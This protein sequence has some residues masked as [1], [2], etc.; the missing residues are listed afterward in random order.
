MSTDQ[1]LVSWIGSSQRTLLV[2]GVVAGIISLVG[3]FITPVVFFQA[4]LFAFIFWVCMSLGC[5]GVALLHQLAGGM[6]GAIIIRFLEAGM[7]TLPL[8]AV[9]FLPIIAGIYTLYPWSNAA[10]VAQDAI[11]QH[12]SGYLNAP[13]FIIRAVVYFV[14][15]ILLSRQI[16]SWS[17]SRDLH[18]SAVLTRRLQ[19]VGALGIV[20]I[21]LTTSFAMIDWVMSLEPH[22][23]S[24][25]Y[26]MMVMMGAV[27]AAFAF[28]VLIVAF[29]D[30]RAPLSRVL[31]PG[32][33]NDLGSLLLAFVMLWAYLAF[34]QFLLIYS[35]NLD[36][37]TP[38]YVH[39]LQGGWEWIALAVALCNFVL[40]FVLLL[41][42]DLKRNPG[43]LALVAGLLVAARAV[44]VFW[45][46]QPSFTPGQLS[47]SW[48]HPVLFVAIGGLWLGL[49]VWT[50]KT[51]PLLPR[52]DR[53]LIQT[54]EAEFANERT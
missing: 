30:S 51:H 2:V 26:P 48:L 21:G 54:A 23:Y 50:L 9:L 38:W 29:F 24:T 32:L 8:M 44:D 47:L 7:S 28:V 3:A 35:G 1:R 39:R 20:I 22:W 15:W 36:Q 31:A 14:V 43:L 25:I 16:R 52:H 12:Q 37:E 11:V 13:S 45:L 19:L 49:Y 17:L 4:Y 6:W 42:R 33:F 5:F 40:P 18:E 10:T 46:V 53:K 27:L 41:F 34:S